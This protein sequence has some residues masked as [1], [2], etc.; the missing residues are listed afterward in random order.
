MSGTITGAVRGIIRG[1]VSAI[2]ESGEMKLLDEESE[3]QEE[4]K[5]EKNK[6]RIISFLLTAILCMNII[7]PNVT[8]LGRRNFKYNIYPVL[9]KI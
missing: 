3:E 5:Y 6:K 8:V 7:L 9:Q 1:D 4:E 2:V